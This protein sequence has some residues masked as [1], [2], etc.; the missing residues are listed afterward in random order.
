[1]REALSSERSWKARLFILRC[2][3]LGLIMDSCATHCLNAY[4]HIPHAVVRLASEANTS[5]LVHAGCDSGPTRAEDLTDNIVPTQPKGPHRPTTPDSTLP[6]ILQH[7]VLRAVLLRAGGVL[8]LD[9]VA[10]TADRGQGWHLCLRNISLPAIDSKCE[11]SAHL[12]LASPI[13]LAG[14]C[15]THAHV[16]RVCV[17]GTRQSLQSDRLGAG[18][19]WLA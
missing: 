3:A 10:R 7:S 13:T 19:E 8:A 2:L 18:V 11:A 15:K 1:M 12:Q 4:H 5:T 17:Q 16:K 6:L 14:P 9:T